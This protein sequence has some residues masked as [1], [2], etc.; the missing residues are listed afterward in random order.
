MFFF[1]SPPGAADSAD[2][3]GEAGEGNASAARICSFLSPLNWKYNVGVK[4][5]YRMCQSQA[6]TNPLTVDGCDGWLGMPFD[7][8]KNASA[9]FADLFAAT[10]LAPVSKSK[11]APGTEDAIDASG[12]NQ[13]PAF[14][15]RSDLLQ[16]LPPILPMPLDP[17]H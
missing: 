13:N 7:L 12:D 2:S 4:T 6:V 17:A 10:N 3:P 14:P 16:P 8:G 15:I 5:T 9:D 1:G 11:V